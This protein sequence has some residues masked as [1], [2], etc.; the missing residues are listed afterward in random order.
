MQL[1]HEPDAERY[2]L[3]DGDTLQGF[4]VYDI[5]GTSMRLLHAEVPPVMRNRGLGGVVTKAVLD[6]LRATTGYRVVAV[7]PFV[8]R[9][10][11][12]HP[13]YADLATR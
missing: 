7:C 1:I 3:Y 2:A 4:I 11:R 12:E 13:E 8:V 6:E 10:M 9:W 5:S